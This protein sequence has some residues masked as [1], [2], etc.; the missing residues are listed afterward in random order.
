[1][2]KV[3]EEYCREYSIDTLFAEGFDEAII[4]LT[5]C[6]DS[7]KVLYDIDK[8]VGLLRTR[9]NCTRKQAYEFFVNNILNSQL[10]NQTPVFLEKIKV[11]E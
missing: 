10:G 3:I 5:R 2:R 1:M 8:I 7:Y 6:N 4:G 11:E 9:T